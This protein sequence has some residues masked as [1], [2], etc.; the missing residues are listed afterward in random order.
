MVSALWFLI[1]NGVEVIADE[2]DLEEMAL[3]VSRGEIG[4][5]GIARFLSDNSQECKTG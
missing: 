4:K 2:T 1:L 5:E 3:A